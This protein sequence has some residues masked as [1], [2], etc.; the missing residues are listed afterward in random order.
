MLAATAIA[1]GVF[2]GRRRRRA[3]NKL[4]N[5]CESTED[6]CLS[7]RLTDVQMREVFDE[8]CDWRR[9]EEGVKTDVAGGEQRVR[10]LLMYLARGGY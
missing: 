8:F 3:A 2:P 5:G 1:A 6:V 9:R 7:V 10:P 4:R